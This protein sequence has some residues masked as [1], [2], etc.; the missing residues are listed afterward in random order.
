MADKRRDGQF[1]HHPSNKNSRRP[2]RHG[3]KTALDS[4]P[5]AYLPAR[6]R[7]RQASRI[8]PSLARVHSTTQLDCR[9]TIRAYC[10]R[11]LHR[12]VVCYTAIANVTM[13]LG[14][15]LRPVY[16]TAHTSLP[17]LDLLKSW[18][19]WKPLA[20]P[21]DILPVPATYCSGHNKENGWRQQRILGIL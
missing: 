2:A 21:G 9:S 19:A 1:S 14:G 12:A 17:W 5:P 7:C 6:F 20:N 10:F 11:P 4:H 18:H 15:V 8:L 13:R 3:G 16:G